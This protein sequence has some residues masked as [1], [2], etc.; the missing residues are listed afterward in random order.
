MSSYQNTKP[1]E[2]ARWRRRD[3][4]NIEAVQNL[5]ISR[6]A[7]E[8]GVEMPPNVRHLISALQGAHGG[9]EMA[10]E[11]FSRDYLTIGAQLQSTGSEEA[12]RQR[13]RRWVDDLLRWQREA[14]VELFSVVKG[15]DIIGTRPD[16]T[17]VVGSCPTTMCPTVVILIGTIYF[18]PDSPI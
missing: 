11:E 8:T 13:V 6:V 17:P 18:R 10:F 4:A 1:E 2:Y 9:G 5:V 7:C 15:G 16:G 12:I 14:G 3:H